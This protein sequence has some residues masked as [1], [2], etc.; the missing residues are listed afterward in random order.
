MW[1]LYLCNST[2]FVLELIGAEAKIFPN[3]WVI[4]MAAEALGADSIWRYHL[5]SIGN[6]IMEISWSY[7]HL[8]STMGFPIL[9]RWHLYIGP[10]YLHN[11]ISYTDKMTSLYWI[12]ALVPFV[13]ILSSAMLMM[14]LNDRNLDFHEEGFQLLMPYQCLEIMQLYFYPSQLIRVDNHGR[15]NRIVVS[16]FSCLIQGLYNASQGPIS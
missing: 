1:C 10:S 13:N 15:Y 7:N 11:G 6:P 14:M 2:Y 4:T 5:T 8:I 16:L 3:N 12:R 9:I